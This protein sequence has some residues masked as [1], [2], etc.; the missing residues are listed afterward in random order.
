LALAPGTRIGVYEITAL[1]GAGGMGEVYR[2]TDTN[3]KRAVALKV[4]PASVAADGKRLARFQREAEVL[5]ALN[6][7]N[8]GQIYGLEKTG[9]TTALVLELVEGP[10]LEDRVAQGAIPVKEALFIAKQIAEA[11]ESAHEQSIIHR[12]LKPSN[13]KVRP[14]GTVKVLDFGLAKAMAP[15]GVMSSNMSQS[16]TIT[17]TAPAV[18]PAESRVS[19]IG[20]TPAYMAPEVVLDGYADVRADIFSLGVVFYE[21][22]AGHNP[23]VARSVMATLDRI[24]HQVP[25][26]LDRLNPHVTV[27]LSH[28]VHRMIEKDLSR[29]CLSIAEVGRALALVEARLPTAGQ[30]RLGTRVGLAVGALVVA[31]V[32]GWPIMRGGR[33]REPP[34]G[35]IPPNIHLAVLPFVETTTD[36]GREF[37]TQGLTEAVNDR[38]SRLT[39]SRHLQVASLS[40]MRRRG[41][42]TPAEAREQLGAN[43]ALTGSLTYSTDR[44]EATCVLIDTR[45]GQRLRTE[46]A[47]TATTEPLA[48]QDRVVEIAVRMIG[49]ELTPDERR[50]MVAHGTTQPGAYDFYLQ[51]RGYLLNFDRIENLDSAIA[52]FRR[53]LEADRR[54]APAY[55]GLGEAYWRKHELTGSSAWVEPSRAACEGALGLDPN[56]AEPHACLGMVFNGTGEYERAASEYTEA[57][58]RE[59]TNDV[60]YLGLATAYEKLSRQADAEQAYRRGIDLRPYY[61]AGYNMLGAYYYRAGRYE[62]ALKMFKQ[63]VALAP[64]SFRGYSSLGATHF[65]KDQTADAIAAFE[66]SLA[67]RPNYVAASNLGTLLYFNGQYKRSAAM[68][69][70]ALALEKG[71]YQV[72]GNLA[73]A[74]DQVGSTTEAKQAH[75][76]ARQ[77][78]EERL[79]VNP[80]DAS[81]HMARAEHL[82][83]LGDNL[84]ARAALTRAIAL[85]PKEAHTLFQIAL[86]YEQRLRQRT[87]ALTWLEKALAQGQTWREIDN[88]PSLR[89]LRQDAR[90]ARLRA[91]R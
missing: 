19:M 46:A 76:Q 88:E 1:I 8:I 30:R 27:E 13:I 11:L 47:T 22:L 18:S 2:A 78:V 14:D 35:G 52:V 54:Y 58:A 6:H 7:P 41:V 17:A 42:A 62:D 25:E 84:G 53:A 79:Q 61:W 56:L 20:G 90:F 3:L 45:T 9:S 89:E 29:R 26:P 49:L 72:W 4:L 75:E 69:R 85:A 70:Q 48:L 71:S 50:V 91:A 87:D 77:L 12:D 32:L 67:I 36:R 44:V 31:A 60:L 82:A 40:D 57:L 63:V 24:L 33:H 39:L 10:T 81:L 66:K 16:P 64:D 15:A 23:F 55:A 73:S 86:F 51:A 65:M 34:I 74:L 5:A 80:R 38:L 59:P 28:L 83:A 21:M 68:F 43:L 37:F